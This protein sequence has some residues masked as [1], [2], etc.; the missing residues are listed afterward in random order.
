MVCRACWHRIVREQNEQKKEVVD[1]EDSLGVAAKSLAQK[2]P[3]EKELRFT[4]RGATLCYYGFHETGKA[5]KLF[6]PA[7]HFTFEKD[8]RAYHQY[9]NAHSNKTIDFEL[10][11]ANARQKQEK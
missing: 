9:V 5:K 10:D 6:L 11:I 1:V 3:S 8:G 7:W 4:L 2:F